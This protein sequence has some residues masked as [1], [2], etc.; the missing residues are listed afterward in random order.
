MSFFFSAYAD[1]QLCALTIALIISGCMCLMIA[2]ESSVVRTIT[3]WHLLAPAFFLLSVRAW[4]AIYSLSHPE[5][6]G[7][8]P[9]SMLL[10]GGASL[11]LLAAAHRYIRK[12]GAAEKIRWYDSGNMLDVSLILA[13][14]LIPILVAGV[15]LAMGKKAGLGAQS[16]DQAFLIGKALFFLATVHLLVRRW[17]SP[18]HPPPMVMPTLI[19]L[20]LL[21]F[22]FLVGQP[23]G[24]PSTPDS[25]QPGYNALF[26]GLFL[27]RPVIAIIISFLLWNY[28]AQVRGVTSNIRWWPISLLLVMFLIFIAF[29]QIAHK[30]DY[31]FIRRNILSSAIEATDHVNLPRLKE[32]IANPALLHNPDVSERLFNRIRKSHFYVGHTEIGVT[33]E[34]L[35]RPDPDQPP[36]LLADPQST[37]FSDLGSSPDWSGD[38]ALRDKLWHSVDHALSATFPDKSGRLKP[39]MLAVPIHDPQADADPHSSALSEE[40]TATEPPPAESKRL[41][42]AIFAVSSIDLARD[43]F[44]FKSLFLY[45]LPLGF[46]ALILL[47]SGQ[48]RAWLAEHSTRRD[49]ALRLGALGTGLAGTIIVRNERIV[50]CNQ[51]LLE[52]HGLAR[53]QIIG[54]TLDEAFDISPTENLAHTRHRLAKPDPNAILELSVRRPDRSIVHIITQCRAFSGV[55]DSR[56]I[57][58][59]SVDITEQKIMEHHYRASRDDLQTILDTLPIPVSLKDEN[60]VFQTGNLALAKYLGCQSPAEIVGHNIANLP[61]PDAVPVLYDP[62]IE[63]MLDRLALDMDGKTVVFEHQFTLD[64]GKQ[65][66][67]ITKTAVTSAD[68]PDAR[69][70]VSSIHDFSNRKRSEDALIAEQHFHLQLIDTLPNPVCFIDRQRVIRLCNQA[71][72]DQAGV[73]SFKDLVGRPYDDVKP[74]GPVDVEFEEHALATGQGRS[75]VCFEY[76]K[77]GVPKTYVLI[78]NIVL[79]TEGAI[80]GLL[81]VFWETTDLVAA[82]RAARQAERAKAAFLTSMS[83]E[84]RTP[85]NGIVGMADLI[86]DHDSTRPLPRLYAETIVRSAKTLQMAI[87]EVMD[88]ATIEDASQ[89]LDLKNEPFS[90]LPLVEDSANIVSCIA[91]AWGIEL[92]LGYDFTLDEK[93]VGDSRRLRQILVQILTYCSRISLDRR[94]RLEVSAA[95]DPAPSPDQA[96]TGTE[97]FAAAKKRRV[98]FQAVFVP[99]ASIT[100]Q[101]LE[102]RFRNPDSQLSDNPSFVFGNISHRIGLPLIW[103]L[104]E[105]MGGTLESFLRDGQLHCR[106][107]IPLDKVDFPA[108]ISA[109]NLSGLRVLAASDSPHRAGTIRASLSYAR[110]DVTLAMSLDEVRRQLASPMRDTDPFQLLILDQRLTPMDGLEIFLRELEENQDSLPA[111]PPRHIIL[112][113]SSRSA[114]NLTDSRGRVKYLLLPPLTPSELWAKA[115][116]LIR[117]STPSLRTR[118]LSFTSTGI[119][120][121]TVVLSPGGSVAV[122]DS[123]GTS[124]TTTR[125][126]NSGPTSTTTRK[127]PVDRSRTGSAGASPRNSTSIANRPAQIP[128]RVLLAEDNTVN[129]MVA[130]GILKRIGATTVLAKNGQE[131]VDLV[132]RG[133]LFDLIFM[134]CMMPV[135][136]GY[137]ATAMIRLFEKGAPTAKRHTIVALTANNVDGDREKCLAAGMDDYIA[138]PVSLNQLRET[139]VKYCGELAGAER[140]E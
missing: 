127:F 71:F 20:C 75:E 77:N 82:T 96:Q 85:M 28:Y 135:M 48:Q 41:A 83:H 88:V 125:Y 113:V 16:I 107:D 26:A 126:G 44:S 104:V 51:R 124:G 114:Q 62:D 27:F 115:F 76:L 89:H 97:P 139:M 17:R 129:Q 119:D 6:L 74:L 118:A 94:L 12:V 134:D 111:K 120:E 5:W 15:D 30:R 106:V 1:Y 70:I 95:P 86:I 98:E 109:P 128:A 80:M 23:P 60:G 7:L 31:E 40:K 65:A 110:A 140:A 81:K 68:K 34:M 42:V 18:K 57:I 103:K 132:L 55:P 105:L 133:E 99:S 61:R 43:S 32:I 84:L 64:S 10:L 138:K 116:A 66:H 14:I 53:S 63:Q 131:A 8:V 123:S 121:D 101:D 72:C 24:I 93:Y 4:I 73:A 3:E 112:V 108:L 91:E 100:P 19:L 58:W 102:E 117:P 37:L 45:F 33:M 78:R 47:L 122:P 49:E 59:D 46:L 130:M 13:N 50:D 67:E 39:A 25:L 11:C 90:L 92:S 29:I 69:L 9:I 56:I 136:D 22:L 52:M 36:I 54:K 79:S 38:P 21:G 2:R 137:H 35:I 87:D